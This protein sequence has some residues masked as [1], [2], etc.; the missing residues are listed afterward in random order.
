[1]A[2]AS[3]LFP[4]PPPRLRRTAILFVAATLFLG[5]CFA[6][7]ALAQLLTFPKR[8]APIPRTAPSGAQ[9]QMLVR[10]QEI[11]YD[12]T[13]ER[14]SAVGNV[15][16]YYGASTLEA[17]RVI[18]DQKTKRLHAEGN[19]RLTQPDGTVT[20]GEIMD[21]SDDFRDGFVD[22]LRADAPEQTRFAA[23][24]AERSESN[25][26]V[27]YNG[28]YTAC[29]PCKDDPTKPPKW[30]VKAARIVHDQGEK[31]M[32]FEDAR[33]EFLGVPL[34]YAPYFSAP[35]PTVKRKTG[36][37]VPT[38]S[39]SS[40]YG[41]GVAVPYYLALAPDYD[42]TITPMITSR[43]GPMLQAEW[44]QRLMDGAYSVRGT[45]IFQLDK[46]AFSVDTPGYRDWRG[47]LES[48]GQFKLGDQWVWGWDGTLLSDKNFLYD[49]SLQK[50]LQASNLLALTPDYALSQLY[51]AGRGDRSY[52]E[53][54]TLYFYGLSPLD[55]QS[56]LPVVHPVIDHEYVF[57]NPILGGEVQLRSNFTSLS[58]STAD[59]EP[60]SDQANLNNLC[61]TITAD[62]S[63]KNSNNCVLR[64]V[65]GT[66]TRFSSE[67]SWR[68]TVIDPWGQ[69]FTP[70]L[71]LRGDAADIQVSSQPG[72]SNYINTGQSDVG[73]VM[74]TA[75]VE[76]RYPLINAQSWGTQTIEPIAQLIFRPNETG[77]GRLPNE[78][79]Q[80]LIFDDSNLFKV[81]KFSGWDRVEGGSRA[82]VGVQYT[83]QFNQ[84]GNVNV[85]F[86]QSYQLFG[87]N[88]F[89]LGGTTNTGLE[90]GL[91]TSRSDYVA[92]ASYQP[93]ATFM[94]T[95]RFRFDESN[96]NVRRT[97][98]ETTANFGRWTT[99]IIYGDYAAQ[100]EIGFL[101]RREG[102]LTS[103]RFKVTPNWVLIG[104]AR[105]DLLARQVSQTQMGVGYID[106]C[107]ILAL[108][109]ITDY[110]YSG[111][112]TVNHSFMMQVSLRTLGGTTTNQGASALNSGVPGLGTH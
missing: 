28:V 14:V 102:I 34:A 80:S 105:W 2:R 94:F 63:V 19:V 38:Y 20:L 77:V 56:Q 45:G 50:N 39:T 3:T 44:R 17:D 78:D 82:N 33:L 16:L 81:N 8:E 23:Q 109:Y 88:S 57:K 98:L 47:S 21:L 69:V 4:C 93:N 85:M 54:R 10:A 112:L 22:S 89:A 75:G 9:D 15:Q 61:G 68:S 111:S 53:A 87:Q 101:T 74:P 86:G 26:T 31:M 51:V 36:F 70:F 11:N 6:V 18:Y 91:D 46:T 32:Y 27:F 7:P 83:A 97:E 42:A 84:G 30:Q 49:Y 29:E 64:G 55:D 67:A 24:R 100:P 95:S 58:R 12:Y 96:F 40:V 106:D 25:Y 103:A 72:V 35:D 90:S 104:A 73:R 5:G 13:N 62:P 37:L 60:I 43:Q 99:S 48:S 66:Y 110:A 79:A 65:P 71:M 92:R 41:F 59:F 52:F 107:L 1:M 76:Y 108:N